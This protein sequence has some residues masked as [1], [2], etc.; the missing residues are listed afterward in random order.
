MLETGLTTKNKMKRIAALSILVLVIFASFYNY[1]ITLSAYLSPKDGKTLIESLD[2]GYNGGGGGGGGGGGAAPSL[3]PAYIKTLTPEKAAKELVKID[4]DVAATIFKQIPIEMVID[5]LNFLPADYAAK[6]F[7]EL[8]FTYLLPFIEAA[9]PELTASIFEELSMEK[10]L[11]TFKKVEDNTFDFYTQVLISLSDE[12]AIEI[13][14]EMEIETALMFVENMAQLDLNITAQTFETAV[15]M[16]QDEENPEKAKEIIDKV[17][18]ILTGLESTTLASILL[19]IANLPFTPST[20]AY[21]MHVMDIAKSQ[22]VTRFWILSGDIDTLAEVFSYLTPE[23]VSAI[24]LGLTS[25]ERVTIYE[26]LYPDTLES[27][28]VLANF[29]VFNLI[30]S[31]NVVL[32]GETISASV[33]VSNIGED[34]GSYAV[35]LKVDNLNI[36]EEEL[37]ML[38]GESKAYTWD[39]TRIE[40][41]THIVDVN[42]VTSTYLVELPPKI[43]AFRVFDLKV[44]PD[45][46]K[47]GEETIVS[48]KIE[49][50]GELLGNH[51]V[52]VLVDNI[53]QESQTV[54]LNGGDSTTIRFPVMKRLEGRYTVIIEGEVGRLT[55]E[56]RPGISWSSILIVLLIV[57]AGGGYYQF[58]W[59]PAIVEEI[60]TIEDESTS[61]EEPP[62]EPPQIFEE[63]DSPEEPIPELEETWEPETRSEDT[64]VSEPEREP[65][66]EPEL[67]PETEPVLEPEP[68]PDPYEI[69]YVEVNGVKLIEW[70]E[71]ETTF[72]L[73]SKIPRNLVRDGEEFQ[74]FSIEIDDTEYGWAVKQNESLYSEL[75][76]K[77]LRAPVRGKVNH[78]GSG[79]RARH[80]LTWIE[81]EQEY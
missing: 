81:A 11:K 47:E 39:V 57:A 74:L 36:F 52:E 1:S 2:F 27:L 73:K 9:G 17:T 35:E 75:V 21:I 54:S 6:V 40:E 49:N 25:S 42:G 48:I 3:D 23:Y 67:M 63:P 44:T 79:R 78:T 10:I 62:E 51:T 64:Y 72:T 12:R 50:T 32:P 8:S 30:V 19:E 24:Y 14:L 61:I 16:S 29:R 68:E 53:F 76:L 71:G 77:L 20:V 33:E 5:I 15:K 65:E 34:I 56:R 59:K 80:E 13:L 18:Q 58:V 55:V 60:V 45:T 26:S 28:P 31:P 43:A 38:A 41:G 4:P 66:P 37:V 70:P 7:E 69:P 46:V 22:E